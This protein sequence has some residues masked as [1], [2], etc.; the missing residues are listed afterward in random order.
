MLLASVGLI[1]SFFFLPF[2]FSFSFLL[3][4]LGPEVFATNPQSMAR[5]VPWIQRELI[6]LLKDTDVGIIVD[7]IIALMKQYDVQSDQFRKELESFFFESTEQ[8]CHELLSF[9]RSPF[10]MDAYDRYVQYE[11]PRVSAL[12]HRQTPLDLNSISHSTFSYNRNPLFHLR[13]PRERKFPPFLF[14][15]R[16]EAALWRN[17]RQSQNQSAKICLRRRKRRQ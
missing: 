13:N 7:L 9:A 1:F 2:F 15:A 3:P 6:V 11:D 4:C 12:F 14:L 8:F 10:D 5:L 16:E 17:P